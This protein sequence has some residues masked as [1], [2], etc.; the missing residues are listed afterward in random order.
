MNH[1]RT[2]D[3]QVRGI[4]NNGNKLNKEN[5]ITAPAAT[6]VNVVRTDRQGYTNF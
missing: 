4:N 5:N 3:G 2:T 6:Q 1:C